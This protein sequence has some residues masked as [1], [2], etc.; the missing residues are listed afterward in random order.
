MATH[1]N[2]AWVPHKV[3]LHRLNRR[4]AVTQ[5]VSRPAPVTLAQGR[6]WSQS[7]Q[8]PR[9]AAAVS[10]MAAAATRQLTSAGQSEEDSISRKQL[11]SFLSILGQSAAVGLLAASAF[12]PLASA[13]RSLLATPA[14]D[15]L[16]D[17]M[18]QFAQNAFAVLLLLFSLLLGETFSML[19]DRQDRLCR[20]IYTEVSEARTLI[21]QLVL[22]S[23][24]RQGGD[25]SWSSSSQ[26]LL[27][28]VEAY[29]VQDLQQLGKRRIL[30]ERGAAPVDALETLLFATSVG[31]PSGVCD[32]VRAIRQAR[33]SR[34]AAAQRKFPL[35][36]S[37]ILWTLAMLA[38][39]IFVLLAAGM[40]GF[41]ADVATQSGHLLAVLSPLFGVLVGAQTMTGMVM[42]ELSKPGGSELF[43]SQ[44]IVEQGLGGLL[45]ELRQKKLYASESPASAIGNA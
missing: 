36:H 38:T 10:A 45:Q 14:Q 40:A 5:A 32:S 9:W 20:A 16:K 15:V 13:L 26:N 25:G 33:A 41:E 4:R 42:S 37:G 3:D 11:T 23:A 8:M 18:T 2:G 44:D 34:L 7:Q 30:P 29:L 27:E 28:N 6:R 35:A 43:R 12:C 19:L 31:V 17:D 22:L 1:L 21:E 24:G 39:G